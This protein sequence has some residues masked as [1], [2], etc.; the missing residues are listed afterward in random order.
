MAAKGEGK[1]I[2]QSG[3]IGHYAHV[4]IEIEPRERSHGVEIITDVSDS[5]IP[6]E[7]LKSVTHGIRQALAGGLEIGDSAVDG[8]PIVDLVVRVV[9][10]SFHIVNSSDLVFQMASIF[11]IKDA[12]KKAKPVLI[13]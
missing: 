1:F 8:R 12:V 6:A 9:G 10:G 2:R 7:Y 4:L 5:A 13:E 3:Y 11:A